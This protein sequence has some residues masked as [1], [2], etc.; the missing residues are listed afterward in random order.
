M[1]ANW[2]VM[3]L[4]ALLLIACLSGGPSRRCY[5]C[6]SI[7]VFDSIRP[8]RVFLLRPLVE[9]TNALAATEGW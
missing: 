2:I 1:K 9:A 5:D 4:A 7:A 3:A 8:I 6:T